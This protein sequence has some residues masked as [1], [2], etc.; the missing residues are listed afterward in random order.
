MKKYV[1]MTVNERLYIS[2]L[3]GNYDKALKDK[4][5]KSIIMIFKRVEL[6]NDSIIPILESLGFDKDL[7]NANLSD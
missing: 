6:N 4:D 3:I 5:I 2:G 1:G 7:I